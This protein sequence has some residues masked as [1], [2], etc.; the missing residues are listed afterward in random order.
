[1]KISKFSVFQFKKYV[2]LGH[3]WD[4]DVDSRGGAYIREN[5]VYI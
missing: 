1:M 3:K 5:A 2:F 4:G